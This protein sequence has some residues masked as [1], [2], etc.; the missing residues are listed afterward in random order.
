MSNCT[1]KPSGIRGC[2]PEENH[3][4][5]GHSTSSSKESTL[6]R[7]PGESLET[8]LK[9]TR[10]LFPSSG[11]VRD[12]ENATQ[13]LLSSQTLQFNALADKLQRR[14][15]PYLFL[16]CVPA[17][18][19][20]NPSGL[21]SSQDPYGLGRITQTQDYWKHSQVPCSSGNINGTVNG[22][23]MNDFKEP[24]KMHREQAEAATQAPRRSTSARERFSEA[25]R[26]HTERCHDH[27]LQALR[28]TAR[29]QNLATA[30]ITLA[31]GIDA[32][33]TFIFEFMDSQGFWQGAADSIPSKLALIHS[34]VS[35]ALEADRNNILSDDKVPEFTGLEAELADVL[36]RVFDLAGRH[37][38]RL[39]EALI[40]KM[41][42]NLERPFKHGKAY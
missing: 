26:A 7:H 13:K 6:A 32:L 2:N 35:E 18:A 16:D 9:R 33:S 23:T 15:S 27:Q 1:G 29:H 25:D 28:S 34:E 12:A 5:A 4:C 37:R 22:T 14:P 3:T 36:V 10:S 17:A 41:H 30:G 20:A 40:A 24:P 8:Y 11:T 19:N 21:A 31:P 38:L 39:G 42:V